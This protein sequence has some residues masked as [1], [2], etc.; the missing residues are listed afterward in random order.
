MPRGSARRGVGRGREG[1]CA[2]LI[3]Y[4]SRVVFFAA[5]TTWPYAPREIG[6][7]I[8]NAA[9]V[10]APG[11]RRGALR[12]SRLALPSAEC[13]PAR[14]AEQAAGSLSLSRRALPAAA[15]SDAARNGRSCASV[16]WSCS[17]KLTAFA[18]S[19]RTAS[20]YSSFVS[21]RAASIGPRCSEMARVR[22]RRGAGG[23]RARVGARLGAL[24][25]VGAADHRE[26]ERARVEQQLQQ[27]RLSRVG[28]ALLDA[29]VRCDLPLEE[30]LQLDER[31]LG[32]EEHH[33]EQAH[34]RRRP[35]G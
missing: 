7:R 9:M 4:R 24:G 17:A 35:R 1:G 33:L 25:P 34:L 31:L 12:P 27:R 23:G 16:E 8:S 28:G 14:A 21:R 15:S 2:T 13:A 5:S 18:A 6:L 22:C 32:G 11:V 10:T 29:G 20:W 3:A 30:A 19:S 26:R